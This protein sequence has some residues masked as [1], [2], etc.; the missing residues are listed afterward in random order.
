MGVCPR[1]NVY[2]DTKKV[3]LDGVEGTVV[4]ELPTNVAQTHKM[5]TANIVC[6]VSRV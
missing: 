4:G 2:V 6:Y 3:A 1:G 5:R